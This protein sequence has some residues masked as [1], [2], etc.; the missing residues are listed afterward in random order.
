[1]KD[2]INNVLDINYIKQM[3][4]NEVFSSDDLVRLVSF[5]IKKYKNMVLIWN[6]KI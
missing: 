2:E 3:I 6:Q 1:M 4:E 5:M